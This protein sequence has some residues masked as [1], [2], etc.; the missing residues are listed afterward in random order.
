MATEHTGARRADTDDLTLRDLVLASRRFYHDALRHWWVYAIAFLLIGGLLSYRAWSAAETYP[1][2]LTFMVNEDDGNP[3]GVG[4]V[5]GQLGLGR[6]IQG[7][8]NLDKITELAR[9]RKII[10]AVLLSPS[11]DDFI[12]NRLIEEYRLDDSW[13]ELEPGMEE[14]RFTRD[15]VQAFN[16]Y[17]RTAL[18]SLYGL[19]AG[20]EENEGLVQ[21]SY[22]DLSGI[23][24]IKCKT[25]NEVLSIDIAQHLFAELSEFYVD[26]AIE[27]QLK[28]YE[29]VRN[30]VDSIQREL[31]RAD[32]ALAVFN[33]ASTGMWSRLDLL[34]RD[35]LQREI[36]K[37]SS[38]QAEAVKNMEY[39][40]FSLKN[41]RPVIQELD[42]PISPIRPEKPSLLKALVIGALIAGI[43]V[44]AYLVIRK[45]LREAMQ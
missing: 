40:E 27:R 18:L 4:G 12:G 43:L 17:E 42:I 13:K 36:I 8:F 39:A 3:L 22:N 14:F 16:D 26:Q 35:Q 11:G 5:L 9:S 23:L 25:T 38:M 30:K 31:N 44:S 29:L 41:A 19:L 2:R 33:D 7:R 6:R 10:S 45:A 20:G 24:S 1:A 28:T 32:V 37:L 21:V 15:S 34:K